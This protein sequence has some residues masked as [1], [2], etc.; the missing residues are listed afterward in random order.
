[1]V[2]GTAGSVMPTGVGMSRTR[3]SGSSQ[4][5]RRTCAWLVRKVQVAMG[6]GTLQSESLKGIRD[7]PESVDGA[8][9]GTGCRHFPEQR[10]GELLPRCV[11]NDP[12]HADPSDIEDARRD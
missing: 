2:C 3:A 5:L 4:T 9:R 12:A 6:C 7:L 1:R 11:R 8:H 10:R